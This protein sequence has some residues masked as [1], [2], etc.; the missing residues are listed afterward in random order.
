MSNDIDWQHLN[1]SWSYVM[2]PVLWWSLLCPPTK[3]GVQLGCGIGEQSRAH[4]ESCRRLLARTAAK[5]RRVKSLSLARQL[6][7]L[8]CRLQ[9]AQLLGLR[10]RRRPT[11]YWENEENLDQELTVFVA[12]NWNRMRDPDTGEPYYYNQAS[13]NQEQ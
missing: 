12:V 9:V 10:S 5:C 3:I 1:G 13:L 6:T 7:S 2:G 8:A 11:G 4:L